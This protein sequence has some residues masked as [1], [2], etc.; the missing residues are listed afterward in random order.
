MIVEDTSLDAP[1]VNSNIKHILANV[2]PIVGEI[3]RDAASFLK[4]VSTRC[5]NKARVFRGTNAAH[6]ACQV[7][8]FLRQSGLIER[9]FAE[10]VVEEKN[11]L[12]WV[13]NR[14]EAVFEGADWLKLPPF[15]YI[16]V[17]QH[18]GQRSFAHAR[19]A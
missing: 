2:Q 7:A 13:D 17:S 15:A 18:L 12:V 3:F 4:N 5:E 16:G 10:K 6:E 9:Y 11:L 1:S 19:R 14:S 8:L